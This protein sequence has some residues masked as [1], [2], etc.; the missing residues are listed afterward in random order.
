LR[1]ASAIASGLGIG[2]LG[3]FVGA[4]LGGNYFESFRFASVRGYEAT[5]QVGFIIGMTIGIFLSE[6]FWRRRKI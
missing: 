2:L 6:Y 3:M 4:W 1:I 5:G